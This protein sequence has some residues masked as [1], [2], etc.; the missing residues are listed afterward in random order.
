MTLQEIVRDLA[1]HL[2][3]TQKYAREVFIR[4]ED[5]I[6]E[7]LFN[8]GTVRLGELGLFEVKE[9]KARTGR[10][11][12]T[13]APVAIPRKIA[14]AFRARALEKRMMK[15]IDGAH[16]VA[17]S[18]LQDVLSNNEDLGR[19]LMA[20]TYHHLAHM[21]RLAS[22]GETGWVWYPQDKEK[23]AEAVRQKL[24]GDFQR[25]ELATDSWSWSNR[26]HFHATLWS[27]TGASRT[28]GL[29]MGRE[30]R[31]WKVS[32]FDNR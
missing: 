9:R 29:G 16:R 7:G 24:G 19:W 30:D 21:A 14:V 8:D 12:R 3:L 13:K 28:A 11:P 27:E 22:G 15:E 6:T 4:L 1:Q 10:N 5:K 23:V 17:S 25:F 32:W 18:L 26:L 31:E 20:D 2:R